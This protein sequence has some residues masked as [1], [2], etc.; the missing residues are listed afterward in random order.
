MSLNTTDFRMIVTAKHCKTFD[1]HL[2][3]W[4]ENLQKCPGSIGIWYDRH[5]TYNDKPTSYGTGM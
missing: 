3:L 1:S 4:L 2:K 5:V